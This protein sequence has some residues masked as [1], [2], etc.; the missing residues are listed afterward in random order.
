MLTG[1]KLLLADD[2]LTV[3]KVLSLTFGDEGMEVIAVG[4]GAAAL[5]SLAQSAPDIVLADVS[6]PEPNG[7]Q[8]CEH[9]K[10][11]ESLRH[12]PVLL[13]R[14]T[15]EPFDEAEARR[16][17]ADDVLTKPFQSI[18][19]LVSK[20]SNLLGGHAEEKPAGESIT[21]AATAA[22]IHPQASA[23]RAA[24]D[25][26]PPYPW[27]RARA[28]DMAARTQP[29]P[30]VGTFN[31][32]DMDDQT[33]QTTPAAAFGTQSAPRAASAQYDMQEVEAENEITPTRARNKSFVMR[34]EEP[35]PVAA[36]AQPESR[37][38][39]SY[40]GPAAAP[41]SE[42]VTRAAYAATADDELLDLGESAAPAA[43]NETDEFV[44]DLGDDSYAPPPPAAPAPRVMYAEGLAT[45]A[46]EAAT[47]VVSAEAPD[48]DKR[49][50]EADAQ[51]YAQPPQAEQEFAQ[52]WPDADARDTMAEAAR[53]KT[54]D[55]P[56]LE[57]FAAQEPAMHEAAAPEVAWADTM[58][59]D[60]SA[61]EMSAPTAATEETLAHDAPA[62]ESADS[63][64][65]G[66][67]AQLSPEMIDAIA[68]RVVELM[69][70]SV[71]REVA[72][73]VVPDLAERLIKRRLDEEPTQAQQ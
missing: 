41:P 50:L 21:Q 44:L 47:P 62:V 1:R 58:P 39:L 9:V 23:A 32:F 28:E 34:E 72:W 10:R 48:T 29:A 42:F 55:A 30:H 45:S 37:A 11:A 64:A 20:V 67:A 40:T 25:T 16:V 63:G 60:T 4:S 7:Y 2:S 27:E 14:G 51:A 71:V 31:D 53:A 35:P 33:I 19:A 73:D 56:S 26:T 61:Q 59:L 24:G 38:E 15:F 54:S 17:G 5:S 13:L 22:D 68:R 6:M 69:S 46:A 65:Q 49:A 3:Q 18:R 52:L 12:I 36:Q 43:L 8:V 66:S 57:T 70:D